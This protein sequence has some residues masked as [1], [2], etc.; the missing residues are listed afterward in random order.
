VPKAVVPPDPVTFTA[1]GETH[2][3]DLVRE[4]DELVLVP[5]VDAS[6]GGLFSP[7]N[8]HLQVNNFETGSSYFIELQAVWGNQ[9]DPNYPGTCA[10]KQHLILRSSTCTN[11]DTGIEVSLD[12]SW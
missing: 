8:C 2:K 1:F 7:E 4:S 9:A 12:M 5:D 11:V 3:L 10:V 6:T